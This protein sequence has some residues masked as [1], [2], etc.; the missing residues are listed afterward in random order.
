MGTRQQRCG[1][2]L[3]ELLVVIAIIAVLIALLLPAVQAAR[4]AG[5]RIQCLN[6]LKQLGIAVNN[7]HASL[8]I[9]PIGCD[10]KVYVLDPQR[11][12]TNVSTF[13]HL[14][15]YLDQ[16][17]VYNAWN[18]QRAIWDSENTTLHGI[19][20]E[21]LLCPS[22]YANFPKTLPAGAFGDG[23][24]PGPVRMAVSSYC[25]SA[26]TRMTDFQQRIM[27]DGMFYYLSDVTFR[28]VTDGL[29]NTL[30]YSEHAHSLIPEVDRIWW[31]WWTSGNYGDTLFTTRYMINGHNRLANQLIDPLLG[32][33]S[34]IFGAS[35]LHHGGA[36]FCFADGSAR[37]IS[38][39]IDSWDLDQADVNRMVPLAKPRL[40]QWLS[41]RDQGEDFSDQF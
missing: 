3:I 9:T 17:S 19:Q 21:L 27:A 41:T 32:V 20:I 40:Y 1:F 34:L 30:L 11:V 26:G 12:V 10:F 36:N 18:A 16:D 2:T 39:T 28:D 31:N 8:G 35:S 13:V 15:P 33:S 38:D 22:D 6:K 4:E 7:Y 25:G 23:Y 37:F 14:L 24:Y 5:R 29:S